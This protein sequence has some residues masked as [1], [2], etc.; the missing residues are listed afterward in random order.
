M[1]PSSIRRASGRWS[2]LRFDGRP[3]TSPACPGPPPTLQRC[4]KGEESSKPGSVRNPEPAR[5]GSRL[6]SSHNLGGRCIRGGERCQAALPRRGSFPTASRAVAA[7]RVPVATAGSDSTSSRGP[8]GCRAAATERGRPGPSGR[9]TGL[10]AG[11]SSVPRWVTTGRAG[12]PQAATGGGHQEL[13]DN[14]SKSCASKCGRGLGDGPGKVREHP[15]RTLRP[16]PPRRSRPS[17]GRP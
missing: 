14:S 17:S 13:T 4:G 3:P 1:P 8:A 6:W 9:E 11:Q 15:S 16:G 7:L 12:V 10:P 2:G 5:S